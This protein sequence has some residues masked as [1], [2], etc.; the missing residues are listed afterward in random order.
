ML[1]KRPEITF[2]DSTALEKILF[3]VVLLQANF[4]CNVVQEAIDN[5]PQVKSL[6]NFVE[7]APGN[8]EQEKLL[9]NVVLILLEQHCTGEIPVQCC[10]GGSRQNCRGKNNVQ[11]CLNTSKILVKCC[12]ISSRQCCTGKILV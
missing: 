10:P 8:K 11:F 9:F 3:N 2:W 4:L 7:E 1:P 6:C 5:I 12:P